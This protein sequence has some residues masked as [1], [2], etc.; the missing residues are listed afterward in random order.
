MPIGIKSAG[1]GPLGRAPKDRAGDACD[2]LLLDVAQEFGKIAGLSRDII[3]PARAGIR[4]RQI[5]PKGRCPGGRRYHYEFYFTKNRAGVELHFETGGEPWS[6][7]FLHRLVAALKPGWGTFGGYDDIGEK[8]WQGENGA[9]LV[10]WF[11]RTTPA[12][13]IAQA[14]VKIIELTEGPVTEVLREF[15]L[16][17]AP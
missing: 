3:E 15:D 6:P 12:A 5:V 2:E 11:P 4:Y 17:E 10:I 16:L 1:G 13:V 7:D 8:A 9:R 14:M